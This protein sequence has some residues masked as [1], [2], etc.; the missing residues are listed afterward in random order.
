MSIMPS[1]DCH[2]PVDKHD[3]LYFTFHWHT[4]VVAVTPNRLNRLWFAY[5]AQKAQKRFHLDKAKKKDS[6]LGMHKMHK[7]FRLSRLNR[8]EMFLTK[9]IACSDEA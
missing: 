9:L 4:V 7:H 5:F 1:S 3:E 6:L 2:T 8:K